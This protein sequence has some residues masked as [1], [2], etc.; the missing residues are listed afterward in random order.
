M[1]RLVLSLTACAL[2]A[3]TATA[4]AAESPHPAFPL[5]RLDTS[6]APC[7]DFFRFANGGWVD[8]TVMPANESRY[9]SF[10]IL[11]NQ[12]R[13]VLLGIVR[14]ADAETQAKPGSDTAKLGDSPGCIMGNH[15]EG[16]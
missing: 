11:A 8:R 6:C 5:A 13:E 7:R 14:R 10:E 3:W 12:N 4:A 16:C 9:G 2:G 15:S 1:S